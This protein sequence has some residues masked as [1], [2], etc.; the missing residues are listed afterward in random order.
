MRI[1]IA[2]PAVPAGV[3]GLMTATVLV[4]AMS[5]VPSSRSGAPVDDAGTANVAV[6]SPPATTATV[7]CGLGSFDVGQWPTD[8]WRPYADSSPFNRPL[9]SPP[10]IVPNS[11]AIIDRLLSMGPIAELV[12]GVAD[13]ASDWYHPLYYSRPTDPVY[14]VHCTEAWGR[15]EVEGMQIRIP[16]EARPAGGSDGHLGV[17]DQ[18]TGWEYDFWQVQGKPA[19]GG[20]LTTSWGGRT[21]ITGDGLGS[22]ATASNFGLAAGVIRAAELEAGNIDHALSVLVGCTS[23]T[24]VYPAEKTANVC[25]DLT[26]AP[27]TGQHLWLDMTLATI[28]DLPVPDWKKTVLRALSTYGA[29]IGDTGTNVSIGFQIESGSSFT[30]FGVTDP[31]VDFARRQTDGVIH[32]NDTWMFDMASGVDWA[33]RLRVVDPCV[34]AGNCTACGT[35]RGPIG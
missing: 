33:G 13:T 5:V 34:A 18:V 21:P 8:C 28:N 15:C 27:A 24:F 25:A 26:D 19:G 9:G 14:T 29:F 7:S 16:G 35:R 4:T 6:L 2:F 32:D 20:V 31:M 1:S 17:I 23:D 10:R 30:S 22:G 12:A 3:T 11:V